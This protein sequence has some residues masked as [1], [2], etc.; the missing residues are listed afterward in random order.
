[1]LVM[2]S[3]GNR[4]M[5]QT[6]CPN[7]QSLAFG[8]GGCDIQSPLLYDTKSGSPPLLRRCRSF[9]CSSR[10]NDAAAIVD[11]CGNNA[12]ASGSITLRLATTVAAWQASRIWEYTP[13]PVQR[14]LLLTF[15]PKV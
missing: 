7:M 11:C 3:T 1:M 5:K 10:S 13:H 8:V 12:R 4:E 2:S 6:M 14:A 9:A 15:N